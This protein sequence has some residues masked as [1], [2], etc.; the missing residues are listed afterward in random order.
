MNIELA[1]KSRSY[2]PDLNH[3]KMFLGIFFLMGCL[4]ESFLHQLSGYI[5]ILVQN[6]H[7]K[8]ANLT[9][10]LILPAAMVPWLF[11]GVQF[12]CPPLNRSNNSTSSV[13]V[14]NQIGDISAIHQEAETT[15]RKSLLSFEVALCLSPVY[16]N[17]VVLYYNRQAS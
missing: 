10:C 17:N 15:Q 14:L 6:T 11:L 4:M 1:L 12:K 7:Q 8:A 16:N 9:F 3:V 2:I 13:V 5:F